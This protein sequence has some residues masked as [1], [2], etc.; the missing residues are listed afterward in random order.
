M[1]APS[2]DRVIE[3][4]AHMAP[5]VKPLPSPWRRTAIWL[6]AS[7]PFVAMICLPSASEPMLLPAIHSGSFMLEQAAALLT[8][9]MEAGA[10]FAATVPAF[11]RRVLM[12]PVLPLGVWLFTVGQGCMRDASALGAVGPALAAHWACFAVT[13]IAGTVPATIIVL[14]LRRG[15][16]LTPRLTMV[17]AALATAGLANFA[18]R[19]IHAGDVSLVVLVWHLGVAAFAAGVAAAGGPR[20]FNWRTV[21]E[22]KAAS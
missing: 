20:L 14:L 18:V 8:A 13:A 19:F 4:L 1:T 16:P 7:L 12:L 9:V 21:L 2:T 15:A 22:Q 17:L 6:A 5:A 11:N 3:Q 10:A